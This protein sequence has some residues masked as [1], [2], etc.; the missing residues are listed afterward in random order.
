M[1]VNPCG[2]EKWVDVKSSNIEAIG[3]RGAWLIVKFRKN[4][5]VYRY[6]GYAD[7][8]DDLVSA[9]SIGKL[10]NQEVLSCT[11]GERLAREEWPDD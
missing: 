9:G 8:Y 1:T 6:Q 10:F 2:A 11:R 4:G 7:L 5:D 3:I